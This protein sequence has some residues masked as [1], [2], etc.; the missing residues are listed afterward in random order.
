MR[1]ARLDDAIAVAAPIVAD[2]RERGDAALAEWTERLDGMPPDGLR[3]ARERIEAARVDADVLAALRRMIGAV[4]R[5]S[6]AQL[7][8]STSVEAAPGIVSERR[9]L[10]V[11]A[12]GICVPSGRRPLPSS[13]V[14][15]A[16]PAQVAGVRR[17][18]VV[19]PRPADAILVVAR[20][21]GLDEIYAVGGAQAV[22]A[23]A[24]GTA[25]IP[26][27]DLVV[28]PGN[29][30]VTAAKLLVSTRVRI[31]LP[32]GP[33]EVVAIADSSA[34]PAR[35]ASSLLAQA[36]HGAD[37][38]ALLLTDD[39]A[40]SDAVATLVDRYDNVRVQLVESLDEALR[41][42]EEYAPEHLELH[43]ADPERVLAG[44][45]NAGS[46]FVGGSAAFG[47]YAAGATHVL[48]TGGLARSSGGL[49]VETFLKP[50]Q[51]VRV[52]PDGARRALEVVEPLARVEG[53]PLHAAAV[54]GRA[55]GADADV[56]G[57]VEVQA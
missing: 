20:E 25:S 34:S 55:G 9:W 39:S 21:L 15:T 35:V 10:S 32:A 22:A 37:S 5:F 19:T 33:S 26:A 42:S 54:A 18:A 38:D 53:L 16:V 1:S 40:L 56:E 51:V 24:Y 57:G 44:V 30:Y 52:S 23:L 47:D 6:E 11:D 3:V 31:D 43:V 2:V 48:P 28:G 27:V 46:V 41:V 7:P 13:L 29:A 12:V 8:Q 50:L 17:I 14:M 45:R 36:E 4:R 49:G